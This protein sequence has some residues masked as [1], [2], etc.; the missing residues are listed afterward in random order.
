M[1]LIVDV[2]FWSELKHLEDQKRIACVTLSATS[3]NSE[4]RALCFTSKTSLYV[5]FVLV[6]YL[7]NAQA[8]ESAWPEVKSDQPFTFGSSSSQVVNHIVTEEKFEQ[9]ARVLAF[10]I[11]FFIN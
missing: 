9:M 11:T 3:L 1:Q 2:C 5:A 8:P 6:G 4:L 7:R 10:T